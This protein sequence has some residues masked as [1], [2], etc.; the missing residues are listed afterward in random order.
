MKM[1]NCISVCH[2]D[3][4]TNT[5]TRVPALAYPATCYKYTCDTATIVGHLSAR[6]FSLTLF[7]L[8]V[9][10]VFPSFDWRYTYNSWV[11]VTCNCSFVA[12]SQVKIC[13]PPPSVLLP[14]SWK[15]RNV[16]N[17]MKN[18]FFRFLFFELWSFLNS[19][20]PNFQWIFT[21]S[22]EKIVKKKLKNWFFIRFSTLRIF[23][24]NGSKTQGGRRGG[25]VYFHSWEIPPLWR[26]KIISFENFPSPKNFLFSKLI[27]VFW[28]S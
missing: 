13:S 3:R 1:Q 21:I 10:L 6:I 5:H 11:F 9:S 26:R 14:F 19:E 7:W 24:V 8:I 2:D 18:Q 17:R 15:M 28:K 25:C 22:R 4:L 16:L 23:H 27:F 12:L 20:H